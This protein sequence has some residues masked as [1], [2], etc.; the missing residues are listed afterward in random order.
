MKI[1]EI[2]TPNPEVV[3]P[4]DTLQTAARKMRELD[5]GLLPVC[6]GKKL[7]GMLTDRDLTTRATAEG[8]DPTTAP[9]SK[10]CTSEVI[11]TFID[12]SE[13]VAAELMEQHQIRRLIVLDRDKQLSGIVSLG[14]LATNPHLKT[15]PREVLER[16]SKPS[17]P[18]R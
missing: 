9:V 16:V 18:E 17:E 7:T 13:E 14:D 12:E 10:V 1:K 5:V 6:D 2:M 15:T 11:Y 3:S 8:L 4:Q